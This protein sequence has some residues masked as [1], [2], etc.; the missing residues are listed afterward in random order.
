MSAPAFL[1]WKVAAAT[2]SVNNSTN[3]AGTFAA[4]GSLTANGSLVLATTI[5]DA[6]G[7]GALVIDGYTVLQHDRVLVWGQTLSYQNGIY[8]ATHVNTIFGQI[9]TF[10]TI[11]QPS[12]TL[13]NGTYN[14][15]L[16]GG[17]GTLAT[18]VVTVAGGVVTSVVVP[19]TPY[20]DSPPASGETSVG[21][22]TG[23]GYAVGN[24]LGFTGTGLG[25]GGTVNVATL[26][27]AWVL[28]R[29]PD[30]NTS[31]QFPGMSVFVAGGST[32][33]GHAFVQP[34][35]PVTLDVTNAITGAL[36]VT[37][38][39]AAPFFPLVPGTYTNIPLFGG[40]GTGA[41][42]T[43]VVGS[44]GAINLN[45]AAIY[46]VLGASTVTNVGSSVI[47]GDLGLFP[48]TSVTGFPPGVIT[49][50]ENVGNAAAHQAQTDALA[51]YTAGNAL[52]P[53]V[54]IPAEMEATTITPGIY[55]F[56]GGAASLSH[57]TTGTVTLNGAG[58]YIFQIA[59]TL[60]VATGTTVLL[61]GGAT[62]ANVFWLVGSS[63]S[64]AGTTTFNGTIIAH[65]SIS[66][67]SGG[68]VVGHLLALTGAVTFAGVGETV[69][70]TSPYTVTITS[71]GS[72]YLNGDVLTFGN[73]MGSGVYAGGYYGIGVGGTVTVTTGVPA[74]SAVTFESFIP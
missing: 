67:A 60:S 4:N 48:G 43:V 40:N 15:S 13:V 28:V 61:T 59:S 50:T 53:F 29:A 57:S 68:T 32:N 20:S 24:T 47:N 55:Q 58:S 14:V 36:L 42:A 26:G 3:I 11:V 66:M 54:T 49:G 56:S 17:A 34:N 74:S 8:V 30:A 18:A 72:G 27:P 37:A 38:P 52:T 19:S 44:T 39:T 45:S 35:A 22:V 62:A 12:G 64:F 70:A 21:P 2:S 33:A 25:T 46:A 23:S 41:G 10:S 73:Y 63:A 71:L 5:T 31:E 9:A 7:T 69:T 1:D 65:A 16:T 51:A 6:A